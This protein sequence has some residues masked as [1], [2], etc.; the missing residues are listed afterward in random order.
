MKQSKFDFYEV[1][2]ITTDDADFKDVN[3][4]EAVVRAKVQ[5]DDG[6]W[7]YGVELKSGYTVALYESQLVGL[8]KYVDKENY[9]KR[10]TIKV[11]VNEDGEGDL[12]NP[13]DER[14]FEK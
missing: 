12:K 13:E 8:G 3:G 1:V 7:Y 10:D 6:Q 9:A 11:V 14:F 2:R 4:K 5:C